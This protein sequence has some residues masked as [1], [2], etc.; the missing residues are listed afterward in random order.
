MARL[1]RTEKEVEGRFEE[2]WLVVEEDALSNGPPAHARSSDSP[3]RVS[4]ASSVR[5][6]R[7]S[8]PPISSCREC[9][10]QPCCAAR[11]PMHT[12]RASTRA[13]ARAAGRPRGDR[14]ARHSP[15]RRR[16]RLPGD[17]G[18]RG[19]RGH[20]RAGARGGGRDRD[21]MGAAR[22]GAR[23]RRSG[24]TRAAARRA[25]GDRTRGPGSGPGGSRLRRRGR[26]PDA[27]RPPQLARDAPIGRAVAG[28]HARGLHLDAIHLGRPRGDLRCARDPG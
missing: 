10:T 16:V 11:T 15:T 19:L 21:R 3:R 4:T 24:R 17:C 25:A 8:I 2:V 14:P 23:S 26:V 9:S 5:E 13:R 22:S 28:R 6:A 18:R 20:V 27:G 12:S 7:R 1:I